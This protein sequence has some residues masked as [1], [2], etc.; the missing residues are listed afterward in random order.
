MLDDTLKTQLKAYL[1]KVTQPFEIVA[2][3]DDSDK[4]Q[5]LKGLLDDIVSLT[6][7]ITLNT[8]GNDA[9]KPSFALNRPGANISL[10]FAGLPMGHEFTSLVLALLQVGGHPSKAAVEVIEQVK[11]IEGE[12]NFETYFSLSCQNCPDVV[13]ALN[14]MAVL[15]PNIRHVAIDGALFQDE[16]ESRQIM[17]VPSIYLNGELFGQGR[18]DVEQIL[19]KIDTG[20]SARDAEK[21]SAKAAFDV[22]VIGGGPAGASAAIYAARKG[23]RTGVAAERFGGQV[24]DTMA[25]ENFISVQETEGPKLARALE[26]HVR[27][28][29][30]DIMN[31]QRASA[32][33]PAKEA[34]G[35]HEVKFENGASLKAKTLILSTGA[36]WREM[37]VP[38]EQEYRGKGVAYCPH[39]DGPL[40]KGKRVAVIGGGNSGVEAAIDL[41]GVVAHVTLLEYDSQLR[42]DAVL[43]KKLYSLPNVDVITSAL[44]SEV[45][46]DG[47]K[48][49]GLVYK[50]RNSSEFNTIALEGIFVQ[51][52][53]LPN[54]DWLKGTVEL[55]SRGE[56]I[57]DARGETSLP[58]IFAAGDVTTVPYKQIVIAVGEG[59]K[60]SLSA[61]DHL[62]RHN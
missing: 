26:E 45:T 42:A 4:S 46:G 52:G 7:K 54:S 62:I 56:I 33:V 22:L 6:D 15:N 44:T 57:V 35:L 59:A 20:A 13:Q 16:V 36:R 19:A 47:Q 30:V 37:N 31:L 34:G 2:S 21:L 60:A 9:R 51:I 49:N 58:G 5:E 53:L 8:D 25:I 40:F 38:G 10:R 12:F 29:E 39:C 11:G 27:Q 28:Y 24:L 17:S 55:S 43:Q 48:V 1:E 23:I 32:L 14:L 50:D 41:A 61:F 18:M 3:L